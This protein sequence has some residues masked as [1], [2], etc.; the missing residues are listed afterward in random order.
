M[1]SVQTAVAVSGETSSS[2]SANTSTSTDSDSASVSEGTTL[3]DLLSWVASFFEAHGGSE[4]TGD[5][6]I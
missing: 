3:D 4:Y 6:T 1:V 2:S 5:T